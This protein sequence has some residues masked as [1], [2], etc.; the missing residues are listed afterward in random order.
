MKS[1]KLGEFACEQLSERLVR[2]IDCTG[3]A[4][5]LALGTERAALLDTGC[6]I[7]DVRA[8]V[9]RI[10]SLPVFVI[11]THGH[12]DHMGGAALFDEVYLSPLD[13]PVMA[14]HGRMEFR[15]DDTNAQVHLERPLTAADF[16]P[17]IG[18]APRPLVDGQEFDLG[19]LTVRMV[20]VP[21]HTPGMMCPLLVEE[22][23]I[24]FGDACG[25]SVLLFDEFSSTVSEYRS[26]LGALKA[27][28]GAYDRIYRNHGTFWSPK[29]LLDN[30]IACCDAV[31]AGTDAR[32]PASVH[33]YDLFAAA[34]LAPNG[35]GRA[36]GL[37]GNILYSTEKAR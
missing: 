8:V 7:G 34:A 4:C 36:D 23:T 12:L 16:V 9:E 13:A 24:I 18:A 26:A 29:E 32:Q 17:V 11:L 10:T 22:R 37:E 15:V 5:Y 25:V 30:V 2:I 3:V 31:L 20:A 33:G 27:V 1:L 14:A 35:H 6:G 21:G 19:G 28:E